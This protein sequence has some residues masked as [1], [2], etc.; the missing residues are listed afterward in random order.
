[1][2]SN[3]LFGI[4]IAAIIDANISPGVLPAVLIKRT[5]GVRTPGALT[6]GTNA[7]DVETPC[8]GFIDSKAKAKLPLELI[9]AGTEVVLL[10][11]N[12]IAGGSIV[13][14]QGDRVRIEGTTYTID[15]LDRDPA[16]ATYSLVC[17]KL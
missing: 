10:I 9:H 14:D 13:P 1:M 8:R 4:D 2:A 7:I 15:R 12:S 5:S 11:G 3:P 17:R 16:A 6:A